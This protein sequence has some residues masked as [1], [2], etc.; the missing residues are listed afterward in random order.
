[1]KFDDLFAF[2]KVVQAGSFTL[3]AQQLG[4]SKSALSQT[5]SNLEKRLNVRLLNRTTRNLSPTSAGEK[6]FADC[7]PT[8]AT[9]QNSVRDLGYFQHNAGGTIRINTSEFVA[10]YVLYPKLKPL[11]LANPLLHIEFQIENTFVDI[12]EKGFDMGV[13]LGNAVQPQMIAVKISEPMSMAVVASPAYLA[14]R[15]AV[16]TINDLSAHQLIGARLSAD[17]QPIEW[18]FSQGAQMIVY[19]P[20]LHFAANSRLRTQAVLDGLGIAWLPKAGVIELLKSGEMQE[21]LSEWAITY[22]PL[23]LYYP[24]RHYH[25]K[26]FEMVLEALKI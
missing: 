15:P 1:M 10:E 25:S 11:L 13:R 20:K 9:L 18:E 14:N 23:Y 12:V 3:A 19:H 8:F 7:A 5:I 26:A 24:D 17:H 16:R 6:L 22:D 4:V 21:L 2:V